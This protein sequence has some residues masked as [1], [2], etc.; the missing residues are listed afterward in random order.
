MGIFI[1]QLQPLQL[2]GA[3]QDFRPKLFVRSG[4]NQRSDML[5]HR[6]TVTPV[7]E[8]LEGQVRSS[9]Q[10]LSAASEAARPGRRD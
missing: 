1:M 7:F 8:K 4:R 3:I 10:A 2:A 9:L 5:Q 6:P